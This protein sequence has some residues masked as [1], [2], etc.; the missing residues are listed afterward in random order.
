MRPSARRLEKLNLRDTF[1]QRLLHFG[2]EQVILI[3][4]DGSRL[5]GGPRNTIAPISSKI[6]PS[7]T[8]PG[9]LTET[10]AASGPDE[11]RKGTVS[12]STF[13]QLRRDFKGVPTGGGN[14]IAKENDSRRAVRRHKRRSELQS[15][16]QIGRLFTRAGAGSGDERAP[17]PFT[18]RGSRANTTSAT[19]SELSADK[20]SAKC[21]LSTCVFDARRDVSKKNDSGL[22]RLRQPAGTGQR[23]AK[24]DEYQR[25]EKGA[26]RRL[27]RRPARKRMPS[28]EPRKTN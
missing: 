8:A 22:R 9:V 3:E 16:R 6:S 12:I 4:P 26:D 24:K 10:T 18:T 17:K 5:C 27:P 14:P 15:C 7:R 20:V 21:L 13:L 11:E 19:R 25:A 23:Q 1:G 2:N 28:S